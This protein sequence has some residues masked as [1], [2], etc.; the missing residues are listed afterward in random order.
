VEEKPVVKK[1]VDGR[2]SVFF[3]IYWSRL[4]KSEKYDIIST[5]P[6]DAGIFELYSMDPKGKLNLFYMGKS[7]YGGL[8][9]ELR[10][11]TDP[12]TETDKARK[13]ILDKF[14]CYYRYSLIENSQDMSD[15]LYF[16][17][18]TYFPESHAYKPSGRYENVFVKEFSADKLVTI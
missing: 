1:L 13:D 16:F 17:A 9:N 11:H 15:I 10:F 7:W 8:R 2:G 3:S 18:R 6:S 4:R 12:E 14:D 5:V